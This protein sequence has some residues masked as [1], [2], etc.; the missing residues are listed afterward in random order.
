MGNPNRTPRMNSSSVLLPASL[1]P[2]KIFKSAAQIRCVTPRSAPKP[3]IDQPS[4]L[5]TRAPAPCDRES[6][7]ALCVARHAT[8]PF[9]LSRRHSAA[10]FVSRCALAWVQDWPAKSSS[11]EL[12][13]SSA[14][15][16]VTSSAAKSPRPRSAETFISARVSL[17]SEAQCRNPSSPSDCWRNSV[18]SAAIRSE[19]LKSRCNVPRPRE[20]R[21][22]HQ[23]AA[24]GVVAQRLRFLL[25]RVR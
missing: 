21:A 23:I 25:Q 16:R 11:A 20:S 3:S 18:S 17:P 12:S 8:T 10:I 4:I 14:S 22:H 6:F 7:R 2:T 15:T 5:M 19:L 24:I 1:G 9:V 13:S